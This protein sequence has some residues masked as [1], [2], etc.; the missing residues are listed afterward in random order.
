[1][2][3]GVSSSLQ[4]RA[5]AEGARGR[6]RTRVA[7]ELELVRDGVERALLLD[8]ESPRAPD[9]VVHGLDDARREPDEAHAVAAREVERG[10]GRCGGPIRVGV[11]AGRMRLRVLGRW[12]L[13]LRWRRRLPRLVGRDL[14]RGRR[15]GGLGRLVVGGEVAEDAHVEA[16]GVR[17]SVVG[18]GK[19][20][21]LHEG[22]EAVSSADSGRT[23]A[24]RARERERRLRRAHGESR[25]HSEAR[26]APLLALVRAGRE[27]SAPLDPHF[28]RWTEE[29]SGGRGESDTAGTRRRTRGR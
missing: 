6:G 23:R 26:T 8:A 29:A 15:R 1:M 13:L 19:E 21:L 4:E 25:G 9:G 22:G 28:E 2:R 17:M 5:Q 14:L 7:L 11:R 18:E 3:G 27:P 10:V 20:E 16:G 12:L 24:G